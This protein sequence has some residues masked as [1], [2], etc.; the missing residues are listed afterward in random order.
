[1]Y[2]RQVVT[3]V[4]PNTTLNLQRQ[5]HNKEGPQQKKGVRVKFFDYGISPNERQEIFGYPI[6]TTDRQE[7]SDDKI[8]AYK[9][10]G[11]GPT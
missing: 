4:F 11:K 2:F 9:P 10:A 7:F 1:M 8:F 6:S 5:N 3:K